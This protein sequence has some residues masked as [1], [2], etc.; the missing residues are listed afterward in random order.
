VKLLYG[1]I[2]YNSSK[3]GYTSSLEPIKIEITVAIRLCWLV[4]GSYI[5]LKDIYSYRFSSIYALRLCFIYAVN[6]CE[7]LKLHFPLTHA[8]IHSSQS[9]FQAISS[10]S[11][12]SG[13]IGAFD[14][15]LIVVKSPSMKDSSNNPSSY[16]SGHYCCHVL[17]VQAICDASC[18]F[19]FFAVAAQGKSSDQ[20]VIEC[21]ALLMALD[22]LPLGA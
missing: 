20:A 5:D 3:Y 6:S 22:D 18:H 13:C 21:T 19:S 14:G 15:L 9:K 7:L 16:Y 2:S 17:N 10:N 8:E 1:N 12:I 4:R 11:V